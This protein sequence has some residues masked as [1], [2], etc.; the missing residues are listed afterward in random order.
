MTARA[1]AGS[2][3]E[4]PLCAVNGTARAWAQLFNDPIT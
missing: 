4:H 1:G 3:T 2:A